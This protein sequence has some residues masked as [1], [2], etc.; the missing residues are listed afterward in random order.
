MKGL[1]Q[2]T[3]KYTK[4]FEAEIKDCND[5][6]ENYPEE[7][8]EP[9]EASD[10]EKAEHK[11]VKKQAEE[12]EEESEEE[13]SDEEDWGSSTESD[14]STDLEIEGEGTWRKFLKK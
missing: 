8:E 6:P 4:A 7:G 5:H 12:S 11:T 14:D 9:A 3:K 10:D 1:R 2:G 13:E